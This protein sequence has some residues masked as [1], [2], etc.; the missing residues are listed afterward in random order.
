MYWKTPLNKKNKRPRE[1]A[2]IERP[3]KGPFGAVKIEQGTVDEANIFKFRILLPNATTLDLKLSEL[4]TEMSIEEFIDVVRKEY[5]TVAKQRNSTEPKRRIINWKYPDLH[6]T[7]GNL[8]KMRIKV[9]FRDFV[10]TKWNFLWLHDGSAEPELYEDMWDLT[11]DTD[12]LKELPDDYTLETALA[13]LIDN[14]LQALWSNERG[15]RRLI[16]VELHR[17]RISIFDSGPGMDGAGGNLVKWGKMGASLHRSVRGQAIGGKPPYLM[18][19]FGMFGYGGPVATMCL[20]RR[21]VVS[22]KTKSCNKVFTLHLEREALVSASSS[23]NCWK[24]KG[25]IRDPSEDEKMSSDHGSFTKVEI[26]EPKMKALDIKHF[27]CKLKDIYFPYIQCDEMSGKTSRP[28][29]FQVNGEDLAGIQGGEVATT[30]LHSCNG[31][32]FTLQLH[33]R[34]NQDPSS[35]P[36]QSGRV[37]LEANARLKCVYFPIVEGEESIKRIIDTLDE[38]GCGI[39]ES[40]EGFSRVSIRRL[41]RLLPDARWALLPFMEPKQGK[42]EKSHMLKRCCSRVKCFIE[43]D[44]GFNP[45][46]HKTDLAQHHPYTKALKNFG[47]RATENEKEVRIEIFRD[48]NNLAPSQLE[49]QY[50]DWISEM[51][52]RY[53]EEIDG[54]LD[55][56]TLVVVSSKIKKL[57]ITSDVLR[58]HKKI[59]RKGKCWTAGQ[60]IKVLKGA[61]M[62]CHKTN[63]FAT[64]EYIILEGLPGDVCGDGRLVCRPLGLPETRSCH[65]L[66]KDENKIIDIRDSL[67]LPIR[68]IDSEK[69]IPVDDIEWEK[70][71]ETYNQKLPSTIEL[72]SDKDCHKL[73]IEG[74][75][76]TVVRAG[77]EPPENIVAV[78][79]PKSFDSKGNYK[80]LDQKFIVRDNLDMIL[81]VTFR[82]GDEYVGESDHIYSVIIPPSSHQGL[83]GLYVFPVKSKHPLL[84]QKA[85]FYTFSFALKEPKDVQFEQVVQ[86][87]VSAEIG[88]WKVL[89]PKQDSLYTVRVGS[90]FEPLCVACYDR[91]GNCILFS[92]V[93]KLTIKLSSPNTILAQVCRPKVSVT[94]DKST[95]KIKEIVLRSN[96]LDAIRPNYEA[97][98]NVSTLDG[99][100]SVAFPCRVLPGTPKRITERPLK[101]RTELRP[102]EI[103]EDLALE[104]LDEYGNHAR[105][106]ENISLRV[107]GFS[108]QD[109]SNIVTEKGLKRKICLVDAD[110]L[111]DLSNILKVSK[112]YGKD[113]FL[114]VISEEEVIFKLQFQTEIRELRAVQKLFKNCKAGSQL[115][116]IVFEITDTQG[117]VDENINDEEKHGQF[118]TLKIKSKSFDIDDSVRYSF[119]HG[120]CIIRSIPL[121]N[122]EGI[123]SFS[124]S[125]SRYP[126]LNLDIEE[127][128]DDLANCG[129][130]INDHERKL[131]MLH[132]RWLHIQRNI[133]DLQDSV[134]GDLCI[135]P[136]MSGKVL[137]QRQI[138]SKCQTPAAVIC[139][140]DEVSFKSSPGD[141]LGIVALLGTVQS[142]ELSRMLAQYI[143]EDKMLAV[144]CKNYAAAYNLETTLGQYVRG[145]YLALCLEDIRIT[146]REP[147]VDPL[148]LMPLKMPSL[149]NGII[150]QG[151]LGYAVNMINIDASYL[152]WRTT[153]GHGLR[154]TLFYRLFGELQV[155]KDRE[156]MM[157]AR[158]C[159]QDGAVSLDG[160]II[161]GNGLLSLGHWEP[162]ILFPVENE[163]MPNTPQSSQAIR[164]LE[165]KKLELI[166]I[167]KQIDEGNKF[168]ESEREKFLISR[169]RYNNYHLSRKKLA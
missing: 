90:S 20:G 23:E 13:D 168:L 8:R 97:T 146:I 124:A 139:K 158:S 67:V 31:P 152:Q 65:I 19:F 56:P 15:E 52:D 94:T 80:R 164:L 53:D 69:W 101:L 114:Y 28:V 3:K 166:E 9:N 104:V 117:K 153:S 110:G 49:K 123:L 50:N 16:S 120:R 108:F 165:A 79:R 156:C 82:V 73:E 116:N 32:N 27:R 148:E 68:V 149:P 95:I 47:N 33:L 61:C 163:A 14:S 136:S 59:Q 45:T 121:P 134:D 76:P 46:P 6:F 142:I 128:E 87:Q 29:E 60:K 57:G 99:A 140:L 58:V 157:N 132:F 35:I 40:F 72:L 144:V 86:V 39:R 103:I 111:V 159:I 138:E 129:M 12:L 126:E 92:A 115:E 18:P 119:R 78:V 34:I 93:P 105:E 106:G 17:D 145:G 1:E 96:K 11:P 155:Y 71:L 151:F 125:H 122:I 66:N 36:R 167:S 133:S 37:F 112:G 51:H 38:D 85:G 88:T 24:T 4:R 44:A 100:F 113:V 127:L 162:D 143:G 63:V 89:S 54:G 147:S 30:N 131:E 22:S 55:E 107:D 161:R 81:K 150:P 102:G 2:S 130:T 137:T 154:E 77:D 75:F 74:G 41:G 98:L 109:G 91:Y 135:S 70:K 7:D 118:H 43:T 160:G 48:G 169:D 21:A 62:G 26:F 84:L 5:F 25:G 141:I 10:H 42:G 64:L 83:H